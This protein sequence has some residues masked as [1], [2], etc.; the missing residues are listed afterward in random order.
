MKKVI[1]SLLMSGVLL[2]TVVAPMIANADTTTENRS[3]ETAV[4]AN[5]TASTSTVTPVDPTDP[6]KP[7]TDGDG[8]NGAT[9]GGGLSLIYAPKSLDFGSHEIDVLNDQHYAVDT[10]SASTKLW[11]SN[12]VL[13]VSDVRG[14]NAG[15]RLT[16]TGDV[17]TDG[18]NPAKG[19]TISLPT[20]NVTSSG[21]TAN[22]AKAAT[23][24]TINLNGSTT[25]VEVLS[26]AK[27]SGAGV[28]VDQ[29]AP[30][31]INL[32][33]AANTVKAGTYSSKINWTLADLPAE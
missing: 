29:M 11:D 13:E 17:L 4:S 25:G 8:N 23:T 22:G 28:T 18:T 7:S 16:A 9:A 12:A 15:W 20:G 5:F 33:I 6:N 1:G 31:E 2:G 14:T 30:A 27:D 24:P 19:A 3:G 10:A 21:T 32:N 26:A